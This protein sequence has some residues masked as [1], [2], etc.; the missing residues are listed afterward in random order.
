MLAVMIAIPSFA[1]TSKY[2]TGQDSIDCLQNLSFYQDYVKSNALEE[3]YPSWQ[4]A[5]SI[6]P[7]IASQNLYVNGQKIMRFRLSKVKD[8]EARKG[9]IDTILTLSDQ[10]A[11]FFPKSAATALDNKAKD[12]I[13][14]KWNENDPSILY[15]N[16][17]DII[18]VSQSKTSAI[19]FV[20]FM[21]NATTLYKAGSLDAETVMNDYTTI[22][23]YI[24]AALAA[25]AD[26]QMV[27]AK[28]D[29]ETLFADCGVASC[30]NLIS[31]FTPRYEA[32]PNDKAVLSTIVKLL[33]NSE[34]I[35]NNL[36][37]KS[38]EALHS[39]DPSASTAY[40]LYK[41]YSVSG[42]Y[43]NAANTLKN[44]IE[45]SADN[46]VTAS[47]YCLELG[48]FY[49]KNLKNHAEAAAA[50][51]KSIELNAEN[52]GR[53]YL[54]LGTI[55]G[56]MTCSGNEIERRAPYW[57]A[58]DYVNKAKAAD[59]S[60]TEEANNLAAQYRKYFPQQAD[61]FM[62]DVMDGQSYT[63]SCGGLRET[64][65]VRTVK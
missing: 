12:I 48:T 37:L 41:L 38:V 30:D 35:D 11:E 7:R 50:A 55:W 10:R 33:G 62:Y 51:K 27:G 43:E 63:V 65:T 40:Y 5:Y 2:G 8:K 24:D 56:T 45:L 29:I 42:D 44:A 49:Y 47:S 58:T 16:F 25:K 4:K 36:Y 23:D 9:I 14:Y 53:A 61:A 64:T 6:C 52:A 18:N 1:Q 19:V 3:A 17:K 46:A 20:N 39:I 28:Q 32:A 26:G 54:L 21:K 59:E 34:C 57:V 60:L 22:A 15:K 13:N 31:L